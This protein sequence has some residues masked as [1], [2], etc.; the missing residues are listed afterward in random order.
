MKTYSTEII[1]VYKT[2]YGE[3]AQFPG[4]K[5]TKESQYEVMNQEYNID[6]PLTR[7]DHENK[8]PNM[9]NVP[10]PEEKANNESAKIESS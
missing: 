9:N 10:Q 3:R 2:I 5:S 8:L 1:K 6:F 7:C 4:E